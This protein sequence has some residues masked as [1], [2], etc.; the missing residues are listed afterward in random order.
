MARQSSPDYPATI[1]YAFKQSEIDQEGISSTGWATFLQAFLKPV[2]RSS[3]H[4][5]FDG[6]EQ[7]G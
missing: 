2:M 6:N 7:P 5:R 3:A 1:Y 4:G